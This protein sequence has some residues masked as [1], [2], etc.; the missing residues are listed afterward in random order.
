VERDHH[1]QAAG[2]DFEQV[3]L[4]DRG[5]DGPAADLFDDSYAVVWVNNFVADVETVATNHEETP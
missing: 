2:L 5:A 1:L 4:L 3:E